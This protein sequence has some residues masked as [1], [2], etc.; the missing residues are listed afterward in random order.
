M[1]AQVNVRYQLRALLQD[2][3]NERLNANTCNKPSTSFYRKYV[4]RQMIFGTYCIVLKITYDT[5]G[6]PYF[7][8][9]EVN[10]MPFFLLGSRR[11][12]RVSLNSHINVMNYLLVLPLQGED[13]NKLLELGY[14]WEM[15][16]Q[17]TFIFKKIMCQQGV[18]IK[19]FQKDRMFFT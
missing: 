2:L 19:D 17:S 7:L 15:K 5:R 14:F 1:E 3:V 4:V 9:C 10:I 18:K 11:G 8:T 6:L 16:E 13:F 12:L